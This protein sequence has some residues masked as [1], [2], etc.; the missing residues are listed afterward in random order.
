IEFPEF[1]PDEFDLEGAPGVKKALAEGE[2][3]PDPLDG[4]DPLTAIISEHIEKLAQEERDRRLE[5]MITVIEDVA[6][7][8]NLDEAQQ[9]TLLLAAK[10]A[11]ERSMKDWHTQ[12]ERYFRNRIERGDRDSA[13]ELLESMGSIKFGGN[14]AD[15]ESENL[16]L[17]KETLV[18]VL[19]KEQI[20]RYEAV[21]EQREQE[22]IEAFSAVSLVAIDSQL[23]LTPEQ[24][25]RMREIVRQS[26]IDYLADVQRYWGGYY[27]EKGM[28]M[29]MANA[30][31]P[32]VLQEF[33]TEEQFKLFRDA[34]NNF[35]HF[36]DQKRRLR[37]AEE[38]ADPKDEAARKNPAEGDRV[39]RWDGANYIGAEF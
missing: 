20:A 28:L 36:W 17:W 2:A 11:A 12:A 16:D 21:L 9:D 25:S 22:R 1:F 37:R 34:T 10:G 15:K 6:R 32:E 23:R 35:D 30:A 31:D 19:S 13:K 5:F 29:S 8:C 26:A 24:K 38:K 33:L 18:D 39:E 4:D 27:L 7:L 14:N 3:E